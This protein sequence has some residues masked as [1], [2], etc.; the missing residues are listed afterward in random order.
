[1]LSV[2]PSLV[3]SIEGVPLGNPVN[4][5]LSLQQLNGQM[6]GSKWQKGDEKCES[7]QPFPPFYDLD[8]TDEE[9]DRL[10]RRTLS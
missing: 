10:L 7:K 4:W 2:V 3:P 8:Y 1:M 6:L 5:K 9:Y